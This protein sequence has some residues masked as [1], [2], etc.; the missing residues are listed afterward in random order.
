MS[1]ASQGPLFVGSFKGN[2]GIGG[3]TLTSNSN[4]WDIFVMR[5][6]P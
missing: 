4:S 3:Q 5:L 2:L 1:W 6:H